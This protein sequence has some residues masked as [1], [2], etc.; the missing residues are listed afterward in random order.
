MNRNDLSLFEKNFLGR[1][2]ISAI[3]ISN[4]S[5]CIKKKVGAVIVNVKSK[6]ILTGGWGDAEAECDCAKYRKRNICIKDTS[7]FTH[8]TCFSIHAEMRA[9]FSFAADYGSIRPDTHFVVVTDGPC[10]QC[11]KYLH[12]LGVRVVYYMNNYKTKYKEHWP[13][14]IIRKIP[15]SIVKEAKQSIK[16]SEKNTGD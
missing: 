2:L 6:E 15:T 5:T 3:E 14:M 8:D 11:L 10:D 1:A 7:E 16:N 13:G 4:N 12:L 9:L